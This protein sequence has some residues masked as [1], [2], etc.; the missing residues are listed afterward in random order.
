MLL[1]DLTLSYDLYL[2]HVVICYSALTPSVQD[3]S[4]V[5][6]GTEKWGNK[7]MRKLRVRMK[8][9]RTCASLGLRVKFKTLFYERF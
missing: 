4:R 7:N 6:T 3:Q 5:V 2:E 8:I 1:L 9:T